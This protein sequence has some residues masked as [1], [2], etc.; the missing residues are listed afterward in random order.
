MNWRR[1]PAGP[2]RRFS[3]SSQ[4]GEGGDPAGGGARSTDKRVN[5]RHERVPLRPRDAFGR[6]R[7]TAATAVWVTGTTGSLD[8]LSWTVRRAIGGTSTPSSRAYRPP[9][10]RH[11]VV[12][13]GRRGERWRNAI[14]V[15][16][17]GDV[18]RRIHGVANF[19]V[20]GGFDDS[21]GGFGDA[22]DAGRVVDLGREGVAVAPSPTTHCEQCAPRPMGEPP[23]VDI[24]VFQSLGATSIDT[25]SRPAGGAGGTLSVGTPRPA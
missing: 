25:G 8:F 1:P 18:R 19:L 2:T 17:L 20:G 3:L 21:V 12:V 6:T 16:V 10:S 22:R 24:L 7:T 14:A 23:S 5:E 13:P 9:T 15:G 11:V 4:S